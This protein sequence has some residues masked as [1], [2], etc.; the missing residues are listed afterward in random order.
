MFEN[1]WLI[2]FLQILYAIIEDESSKEAKTL[3]RSKKRALQSSLIQE[4]KQQYSEA[5]E[6]YREINLR[7]YETDKEREVYVLSSNIDR[8]EEDHFVRLRMT[9]AEKNRDRRLTRDNAVDDLL[10]FGNY[11][12][13]DED[14]GAL[15]GKRK[16]GIGGRPKGKRSKIEKKKIKNARSKS[17]HKVIK[18]RQ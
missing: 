6:E 11:M 17:K 2:V 3:E 16:A 9:K 7:K 14:G 13:R 5:P 1:F 12:M 8:Y 4:L 15:L 10:N 18:K